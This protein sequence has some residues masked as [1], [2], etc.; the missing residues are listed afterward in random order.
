LPTGGHSNLR[1]S[2]QHLH[3]IPHQDS[4]SQVAS[5]S[6]IAQNQTYQSFLKADDPQLLEQF[7]AINLQMSQPRQPN[8]PPTE[9][10]GVNT[11][12]Y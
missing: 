3:T 7:R 5:S 11:L 2:P 4:H 12:F 9:N 6:M 10:D 8:Y 1:I